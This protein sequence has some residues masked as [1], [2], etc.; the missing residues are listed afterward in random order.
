MI[1]LSKRAC[2]LLG[3][4]CNAGL[5]VSGYT[6][7]SQLFDTNKIKLVLL[8]ADASKNTIKLYSDKALLLKANFFIS[9]DVNMC[10]C[11][12]HPER[13]VI[14]VLDEGFAREILK[15]INTLNVGV[16]N[17]NE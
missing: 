17:S 14:A 4:A 11:V 8:S 6:A 1:R 7:V 12:G 15:E 2:S 10:A 9:D 16:I 5:A 3:L 13:K